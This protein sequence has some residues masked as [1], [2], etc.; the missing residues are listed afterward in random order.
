MYNSMSIATIREKTNTY[1]FRCLEFFLKIL[2][3]EWEPQFAQIN[4]APLNL[5]EDHQPDPAENLFWLF[6]LFAS[7]LH[8]AEY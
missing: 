4:V 2:L 3:N 1:F 6:Y 7:H 5:L 8:L